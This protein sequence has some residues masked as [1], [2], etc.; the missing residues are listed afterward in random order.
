MVKAALR[1][2]MKLV[3]LIKVMIAMVLLV[4]YAASSAW[5]LVANREKVGVRNS[6][7]VLVII[8]DEWWK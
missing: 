3:L 8:D 1:L 2:S 4:L 6:C 5:Y 7:S